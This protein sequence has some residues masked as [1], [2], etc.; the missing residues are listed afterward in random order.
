MVIIGIC[1]FQGSGKDTIGNYLISKYNFVR[2]S[3]AT[4]VK[5]V[6]S[7]LFKWD[8][9][10]LEGL[11]EETRAQRNIVDEWWSDALAIPNLTPR[12]M[13]QRIGTDLFREHFNDNIWVKI[14]EKKIIDNSDKNIVITDCRFPNEIKMIRDCGGIIIHVYRTLPTW[15]QDFKENKINEEYKEKALENIHISEISWITE[16][17]DYSIENTDSIEKLENII[18]L[19]LKNNKFLI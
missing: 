3:F 13:M 10:M 4:E 19:F 15:F 5:D 18:D 7:C 14:T 12:M 1:G 2:Y 16:H 9:E 8:R 17:F 11:T 6:L